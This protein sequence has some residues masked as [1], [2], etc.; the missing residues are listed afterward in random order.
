MQGRP[1]PAWPRDFQIEIAD[2]QRI[3]DHRVPAAGPSLSVFRFAPNPRVLV[4]VFASLREQG[5]MLNRAAAFVEKANQP[6]DRVLT[7]PELD[8]AIRAGGDTVETFYYGHDYGAPD[9]T[10]FF[11]LADR[12]G[13]RLTEEEEA[14]RR[15]LARERWFEPNAIGGLLSIPQIGADSHV[16]PDARAAILHHELSHGEYFTNPAYAAFVRKFWNQTLTAGERDRMRRFLLSLGYEPGLEHVVENE[17]QAYLM[18]TESADFFTPEMVGMTK[19]RLTELRNAFYRA[20]P[21][22]WL[23]DDLGR[24]IAAAT[25][26]H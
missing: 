6:H 18:F 22:G 12:A 19:A 7:D 24:A 5:N 16:T 10:R 23:R 9:L 8:A 17:A 21:A 20:M 14:L 2:E 1:S 26:R 13:V 15:L 11:A 25:K 3:R 4:L